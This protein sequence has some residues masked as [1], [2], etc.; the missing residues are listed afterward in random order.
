MSPD[1]QSQGRK[2]AALSNLYTIILALACGTVLATA[3]FV[4]YKCLTQ[5]GT[6]YK[7]P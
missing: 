2:I 4:L 3:L 5:Y 6:F 1:G 7:I